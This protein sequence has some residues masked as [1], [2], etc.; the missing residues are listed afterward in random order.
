MQAWILGYFIEFQKL[1][2]ECHLL[3]YYYSD[4]SMQ[5]G[6]NSNSIAAK[7][8]IAADKFKKKNV[9]ETLRNNNIGAIQHN[10]LSEYSSN[11]TGRL[12]STRLL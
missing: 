10:R 2:M 11:S 9:I 6:Q 4:S 1:E 8:T 7:E 5:R 3:H 12:L